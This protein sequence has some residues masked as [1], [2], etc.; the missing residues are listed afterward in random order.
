MDDRARADSVRR[1]LKLSFRVL[2][3]ASRA[4]LERWK[5]LDV[6]D[7]RLALPATVLIERDCSIGFVRIGTARDRLAPEDVLTYLRTRGSEV[8]PNRRLVAGSR[9]WFYA[10]GNVGRYGWKTAH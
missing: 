8:P 6:S 9:A 4:L 1:K 10:I 2:W 5:L 3:G 7:P